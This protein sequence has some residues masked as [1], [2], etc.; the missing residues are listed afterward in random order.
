[1]H[2]V[3][4]SAM[5]ALLLGLVLGPAP[6]VQSA[7]AAVGPVGAPAAAPAVASAPSGEKR[8]RWKPRPAQY[9]GTTTVTDIA[10]PMD[11]GTVLRGDLMR[12]TKADGSVVTK[13]LP[14]I[15]TITAYNKTVLA[16]GGLG[17]GGADYL[18]KRGYLQL[19]VD[20]RGTGSSRRRLA[21][22]RSSREQGRRRGRELGAQ[23]V[24]EQRE[25]RD[26]RPVVHGHLAA[27]G[28][29]RA[30]R[31]VSRRS[32]RRSPAPTSTATSSRPAARSTSRSSR[33]GWAWSPAPA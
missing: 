12:P 1:M 11:D 23:A 13:K 28:G 26:D 31:R 15:I 30:S 21:G 22:V 3:P 4:G 17:A 24:V 6:L 29:V 7:E 32:S 16:S 20:A 10:I 8:R 27:L 18:V 9:A 2:G 14:V 19:T 33:S 25:V 5:S